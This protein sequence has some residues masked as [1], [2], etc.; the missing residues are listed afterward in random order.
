MKHIFPDGGLG[1]MLLH[2]PFFKSFFKKTKDKLNIFHEVEYVY[3]LFLNNPYINLFL[4][5]GTNKCNFKI[6]KTSLSDIELKI[7]L[8]KKFNIHKI[9]QA[10]H[11]A[12]LMPS[13]SYDTNSYKIIGEMYNCE[14]TDEKPEIFLTSEEMDEANMIISQYDFVI[15]VNIS[16]KHEIKKWSIDKWKK[17]IKLYPKIKFIQLGDENETKIEGTLDLLGTP[18]RKQLSVLA[19][20][21]LY[22]GLDSFWNHAAR[23]LNV[24]SVILFGPT[25]PNI[26]GYDENINIY[27]KTRCSPCIDWGIEECPYGKKCMNDIQILDVKK[28]IDRLILKD[29]SGFG[30]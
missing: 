9:S 11:Y 7:F 13:L 22:V 26:W 29:V 17:I 5:G 4:Y 28:A 24:K 25:N 30:V 3:D 20:S 6:L 8:E 23:A 27:K 2:T 12:N 1:D 19:S 10:K 21:N 14:I 15:C 18:I 16:S